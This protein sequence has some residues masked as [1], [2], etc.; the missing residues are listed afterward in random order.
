[1]NE[2][3]GALLGVGYR[4]NRGEQQAWEE[5]LGSGHRSIAS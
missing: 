3:R 4:D 5:T 1:L 2:L